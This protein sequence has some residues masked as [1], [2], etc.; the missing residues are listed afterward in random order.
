MFDL[1]IQ[2]EEAGQAFYLRLTEMFAH[3]SKAAE[4]WWKMAADEASHIHLLK[5]AREALT[6]EQLAAPADPDLLRAA[7]AAAAFSPER[8]LAQVQTLEDAYQMAHAG[9][10]SEFNAVF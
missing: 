1:L 9:E 7:R 2:A 5:Q 4:I 10:N 8:V 6:P 3:D